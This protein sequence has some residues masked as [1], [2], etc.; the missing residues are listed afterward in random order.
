DDAVIPLTVA[1]QFSRRR[2]LD[3][4]R[5]LKVDQTDRAALIA[6]DGNESKM[7][8]RFLPVARRYGFARCREDCNR[9]NDSDDRVFEFNRVILNCSR[10][11]LRTCCLFNTE[12]SDRTS[13]YVSE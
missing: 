10:R 8:L 7:R 12:P 2:L 9:T 5:A 1:S 4:R 11:S 3:N 6:V 13:M